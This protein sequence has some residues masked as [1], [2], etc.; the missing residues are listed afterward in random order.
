MEAELKQKKILVADDTIFIRVEIVKILIKLGVPREN[1]TQCSDG[2][3]ALN[4]LRN[5]L[6]RFD[7]V[8]SDWNMP[9]LNG[10]ELLKQV[11]AATTYVKQIPF[12]LITTVSEK[13]KVVE[14]IRYKVN[15]YLIKPVDADALKENIERIFF[16]ATNDD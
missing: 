12:M 16:G 13:D 6:V 10:L 3:E 1:I 5:P 8:L 2:A 11:R 14:A 15:G 4:Q 7:L 9:N